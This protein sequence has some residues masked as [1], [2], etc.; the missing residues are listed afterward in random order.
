MTYVFFTEANLSNSIE[1][2]YIN[3]FKLYEIDSTLDLKVKC[4]KLL[5]GMLTSLKH[6]SVRTMCPLVALREKKH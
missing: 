2:C 6:Q 5:K 3:L 4:L 1:F